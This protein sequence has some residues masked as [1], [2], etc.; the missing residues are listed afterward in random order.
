MSSSEAGRVEPASSSAK[1]L[2]AIAFQALSVSS[3]RS[4]LV[5]KC[6]MSRTRSAGGRLVISPWRDSRLH[7][8]SASLEATGHLI[9]GCHSRLAGYRLLAESMPPN[10]AFRDISQS[11]VRRN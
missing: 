3:S 1:R 4:R 7:A 11:T 9:Q 10:A 2:A 6:S 5:T 8:I